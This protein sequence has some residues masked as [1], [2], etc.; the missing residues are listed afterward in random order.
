MLL[1]AVLLLFSAGRC[2]RFAC[3]MLSGLLE[4][5]CCLMLLIVAWFSGL[6]LV[7]LVLLVALLLGLCDGVGV[8]LWV[9]FTD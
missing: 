8:G 4:V 7:V 6:E 5:V 9:Y 2:S 1:N 3:G